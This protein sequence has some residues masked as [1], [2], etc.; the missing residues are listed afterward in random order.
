MT[1]L[2]TNTPAVAQLVAAATENRLRDLWHRKKQLHSLHRLLSTN[3]ADILQAI[4]SDDNITLADA[5]AVLILTLREIKIH[6]DAL[7]LRKEL[8]Q[9]YNVK[10]GQN[11]EQRRSCHP[12]V[13]V[14]C[15]SFNS[16]HGA[17][18]VLAAA[19]AAGYCVLFKERKDKRIE[20]CFRACH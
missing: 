8:K 14:C 16:L 15:R 11:N 2:G 7:D 9:E 6:F 1:A 3:S 4:S 20:A 19:T 12:L 18:S 10:W 17:L 13:Y 5:Q